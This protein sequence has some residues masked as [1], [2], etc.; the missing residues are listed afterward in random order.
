MPWWAGNGCA[1]IISER[2]TSPPTGE[3]QRGSIATA[4]RRRLR[5]VARRCEVA[6]LR[7]DKRVLAFGV[8]AQGDLR[9]PSRTNPHRWRRLVTDLPQCRPGTPEREQGQ[10]G[11]W[12]E[13]AS[14]VLRGREKET[15]QA[16]RGGVEG[17]GWCRRAA[18]VQSSRPL[19]S[20]ANRNQRQSQS[21]P[22]RHS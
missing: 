6:R 12:E 9:F 19:C 5:A 15:G 17:L 20:F 14:E 4:T 11:G 3:R 1:I 2:P 21:R 13:R 10:W 18:H 7:W 16:I 22:I 8:E